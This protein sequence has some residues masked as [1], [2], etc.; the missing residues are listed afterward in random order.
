MAAPQVVRLTS[1]KIVIEFR[2]GKSPPGTLDS[3]VQKLLFDASVTGGT[4][5]L[6]LN[7]VAT[8]AITW[9][10]NVSMVTAIENAVNL[11]TG[12]VCTV[13]KISNYE[14][15]LDFTSGGTRWFRIEIHD[16]NSLTGGAAYT[17][18]ITWGV[19]AFDPALPYYSLQSAASSFSYTDIAETVDVT[20][21]NAMNGSL[22]KVKGTMDFE[23]SLY[24]AREEWVYAL[25]QGQE[26]LLTVWEQGK[27]SGG[28]YFGFYCL[29]GQVNK[30]Y[31]DH[32]KLELS[33]TGTRQGD[34][35]YH[36]GTIY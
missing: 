4:Y 30:T 6:W 33:I 15:E 34:M 31:P 24:D 13:T 21:I 16:Q 32:N 25:F 17:Y 35:V 8:S 26:G 3:H 12:N 22:L 28:T 19:S 27:V 7:G 9:T 11:A 10:T 23:I 14:F 29:I 1:D 36:F 18:P 2:P 20:G 5:K